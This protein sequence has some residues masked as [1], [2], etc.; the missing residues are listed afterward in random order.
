MVR[1]VAPKR[2]VGVGITGVGAVGRIPVRSHGLDQVDDLHVERGIDLRRRARVVHHMVVGV[3]SV[4]VGV[5]RPGL[6]VQTQV[7]HGRHLG[8]FLWRVEVHVPQ[9]DHVLFRRVVGT[10]PGGDR[11]KF[12]LTP[13]PVLGAVSRLQVDADQ[14]KID[15]ALSGAKGEG[16]EHPF[17]VG[18][19]GAVLRQKAMGQVLGLCDL[20]CFEEHD[21]PF[22]GRA[23]DMLPVP[24][25]RVLLREPE[26]EAVRRHGVEE[27]G[28]FL[29]GLVV[30]PIGECPC[31]GRCYQFLDYHHITVLNHTG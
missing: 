6:V 7:P 24:S 2:V 22:R 27:R 29:I 20:R 21:P 10:D 3:R 13:G 11:C 5:R 15:G 14:H 28:R 25:P 31:I 12:V 16:I 30:C 17:P 23:V 19:I 1:V 8:D 9:D 4:D 18:M 26:G